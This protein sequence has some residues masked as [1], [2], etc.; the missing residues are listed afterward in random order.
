MTNHEIDRKIAEAMGYR[1]GKQSMDGTLRVYKSETNKVPR[2]FR[3]T[4]SMSDAWEV[5]EKFGL[6]DLRSYAGGRWIAWFGSFAEYDE[7]APLAI[8]LAALKVIRYAGREQE[9]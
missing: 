7:S 4:E 5:A 2:Y 1:L 8:C 3:P 6:T 9:R